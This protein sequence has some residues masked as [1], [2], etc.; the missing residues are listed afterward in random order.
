[1]ISGL[2]YLNCLTISKLKSAFCL[3]DGHGSLFS[4]SMSLSRQTSVWV[5]FSSQMC[6]SE[7]YWWVI[8]CR[9]S[10]M[11]HTG[12]KKPLIN[13]SKNR[14][15]RFSRRS[16]MLVRQQLIEWYFINLKTFNSCSITQRSRLCYWKI[17]IK[18][19]EIIEPGEKYHYKS[20]FHYIMPWCIPNRAIKQLLASKYLSLN[21]LTVHH[22]NGLASRLYGPP[23]WLFNSVVAQ[24]VEWSLLTS[25]V[26]GS[27][28]IN[29]FIQDQ[30]YLLIVI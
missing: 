8:G 6:F 16:K 18:V 7:T 4:M 2:G 5:I 15:Q 27:N 22:L 24:L 1:M 28:S 13:R 9:A 12:G 17:I 26:R 3:V 11:I 14:W 10:S 29:H 20:R 19:F 21:C 23:H 25:E 30:F